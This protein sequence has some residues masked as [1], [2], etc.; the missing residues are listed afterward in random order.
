M[1]SHIPYSPVISL[2]SEKSHCFLFI[3]PFVFCSN[4]DVALRDMVYWWTWQ[5]YVY[6]WTQWS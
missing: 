2:K 4:I 3:C 5:Y 1:A 6:S